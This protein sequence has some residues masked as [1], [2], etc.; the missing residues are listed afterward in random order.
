[1]LGWPYKPYSY[2][3]KKC[4]KINCF[5]FVFFSSKKINQMVVTNFFQTKSS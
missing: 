2:K 5:F 1:M 4:A 3:G